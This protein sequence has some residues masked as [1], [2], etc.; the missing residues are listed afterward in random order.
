MNNRLSCD[1]ANNSFWADLD[2]SNLSLFEASDNSLVELT[3]LFNEYLAVS[4]DL[5]DSLLAFQ[6]IW[7]ELLG[8]ESLSS[9]NDRV[10]LVVS[11]SD[12]VSGHSD[13]AEKNGGVQLTTA[14]DTNVENILHVELEIDPRTTVRDDTSRIEKLA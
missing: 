13:R 5:A 4:L 12:I 2:L 6:L 8:N 1:H 9:E 3:A 7:T 14:I 10:G 11:R